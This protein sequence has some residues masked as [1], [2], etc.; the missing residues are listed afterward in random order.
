MALTGGEIG[1]NIDGPVATLTLSNGPYTVITWQMRQQMA[2]ST[3][4]TRS[5][6]W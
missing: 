3:P 4:T 5:G 1:V 6:P 2:T